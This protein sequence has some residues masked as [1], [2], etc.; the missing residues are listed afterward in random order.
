M[1]RSTIVRWVVI[2]VAVIVFWKWGMPLLSG[3]GGSDSVQNVPA[4]TYTNAPDFTPDVIDPLSGDQK[5]A[6][7]PKEGELCTVRGNRFEA[8]LS[9][10]GAGITHFKLLD[11]RYAGSESADM[12]TTPD[13]ERWRNLR[14]TFR[15]DGANDQVKYD[16]F[17]WKLEALGGTGCKFT[18]DDEGVKIVKTIT[19]GSR[20]FE[21]D[22]ETAVT[23]LADATKRHRVAIG[24]FAYRL[25]EEVKGSLGRQSPFI[26]E[27]SCARGKDVERKG[28]DDFKE[29]WFS[30]PLVDRYAA[31]SNTY[32]AQAIVPNDG[33][34]DKPECD[35]LSEQW[36][37]ANQKAD[38]DKAGHVFH[39][40]VQYP[41]RQLE[42]NQTATYKQIAFFGPKERDVLGAA[43]GG[44]GLGDLIN[45]GFFTVVAKVLV[46]FLIWIHSHIT[47][48][49]WG[50]AIVLMTIFVRTVLFPLTWKSIKSTVAMRRLK[51]EIDAL[52]AKFKD[53]AQA[54]N[55]AMM[56]LWRTHKVN[57]LG[58]CLPQLVQMPVWFAMYTTLQTA[59]EMYHTKFLWFTD[60]SAPDKFYILPLV[61]GGF[62]ILQQRIVPQQGMDPMQQKMMT[63]LLP[64]IFTVMML[65]LPAALG[66][67]MLTNSILGIVQQLAVEKFAPRPNSSGPKN[68][69]VVKQGKGD[70]GDAS[71]GKGASVA[72]VGKG[73]ARV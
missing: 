1:D 53:D 64:I 25:N 11:P 61:L 59:V 40:Q 29:G 21:L 70:D 42:P 52:N 50:I 2:A 55:M 9:T 10:R 23:N 46:G 47:F 65:F 14:T 28:A 66:V 68:D 69:I 27:L 31:V 4:E 18:Y 48:G 43:A 30:Q 24:A 15:A 20:A 6:W 72:L 57:P 73:K 5:E 32:F 34:G 17:N 26:T 33:G 8:T 36:F 38:D 63:W 56:Q 51:P 16:R 60:L 58:G 44:R 71:Q 7:S 35:L 37:G 12:S 62:M 49:N 13:L 3:K 22:V 41:A 45:L 67:Y 19:A 39:A 54:K